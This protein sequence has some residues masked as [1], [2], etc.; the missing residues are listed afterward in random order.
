MVNFIIILVLMIIILTI[1]IYYSRYYTQMYTDEYFN[2]KI[3]I[4]IE[5]YF[6]KNAEAT[7]ERINANTSSIYE[8]QKKEFEDF[9]SNIF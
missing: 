4:L 6:N 3:R 9:L 2:T 8:K 1:S 5:D 7:I